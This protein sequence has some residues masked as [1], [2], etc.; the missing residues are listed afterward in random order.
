MVL[1]GNKVL[2]QPLTNREVLGQERKPMSVIDYRILQGG[3]YQDWFDNGR[4]GVV[5]AVGCQVGY[6]MFH[7]TY[8]NYPRVGNYVRL[9]VAMASNSGL[10][11]PDVINS[12]IDGFFYKKPIY[13]YDGKPTGEEQLFFDAGRGVMVDSIHIQEEYTPEE[14]EALKGSIV[15]FYWERR[16]L[17]VTTDSEFKMG[18]DKNIVPISF[19]T[20]ANGNKVEIDR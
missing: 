5:R 2:V 8:R 14:W 7:D 17:G 6:N 19:L 11:G 3:V 10:V 18:W 9:S 20:P 15:K 1:H 4:Y 13:G 16:E 12:A